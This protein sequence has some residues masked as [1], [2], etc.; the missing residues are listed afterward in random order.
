MNNIRL[1]QLLAFIV[2]VLS[3]IF[4]DSTGAQQGCTTP[5]PYDS[6]NTTSKWQ[7]G[8]SVTVIFDQNSSFTA[9]EI[10]AMRN[11][12]ENWNASNGSGGNNSGVTFTGFAQGPAPND[13]ATNVLYVTRGTPVRNG[14]AD[15]GVSA[16]T[17]S[18][19]YTSVATTR[20]REG[21]NWTYPPDLTSVMAHEIGH[22][23][24]LGDCY[25][26]CD[27]TS[28]MGTAGNCHVDSN[29]QPTG[30]FLGPTSCDNA[31]A[32]QYGGYLFAE[33]R[34]DSTCDP[35]PDYLFWCSDE[36]YAMDW[37]ACVCGP[38]PIL[39]DIAGNGFALTGVQDGVNFDI[40]A[41]GLAERLS[42][43]QGGSDDAWLAFDRN[44]NGTI[45]NGQ[46]LF[47]NFTPQPNP[48]ADEQRNGFLALAEYDKA[49]NGGNDDGVIDNRDAIFS[50][51]RLWQ[52]TNHNG[53]SEP[54]ELHTLPSL[55]VDSIS[56]SYKESKRTDQYGNDFR[57]R[58]KVDD[59]N[60]AHV[61]RWAW[62]VFL[63]SPR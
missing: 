48:P 53:I 55:N 59:A 40:N 9:N 38:T 6:G 20:I 42:W 54:S 51:L 16:N 32:R 1:L 57:Y 19:P 61:G 52:D 27:G 34:G 36:H 26:S 8:A 23:F 22:S 21:I 31:A 15:T 58:A 5:P 35:T 37:D 2:C 13:T 11:A 17:I 39:I 47:G 14:V 49:A 30:C 18:Y 56:L 60:H 28:V 3:I 25:P 41:N 24:G 44:G 29:G 50:S 63:V 45:D 10:N 46:E 12:A 7:P 62:D 4:V 43:T 33:S